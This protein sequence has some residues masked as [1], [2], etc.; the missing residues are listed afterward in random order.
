MADWENL[1]LTF[2]QNK[3]RTTRERVLFASLKALSALFFAGWWIKRASYKSGLLPRKRLA[4]PVISVGNL[5]TGG[6]GK[7]P[8]VIELAK[9]FAGEGRRVAILSR[10]YGRKYKESSLVWVSDGKKILASAEEGGDEPVLIARSVPEAA[11]VVCKDRHRAG[12][13]AMERFKPDL[14]ILDDGYQRRFEVRRDLDIV[15]IDG[16]NPFSTGWVLPAGLLREPL[17]ALSDAGVFVINKVNMSRSPEDIRTVLQHHNPRAYLV[18]AVYRP[19]RLRD[20]HTGKEM[21]PSALDR[22]SVGVFSGVANSLSVVRTL[23]EHKVLVRH[24][25]DLKDHYAYTKESLRAILADARLRGLQYLVTTEKDEVKLPRDMELDIPIL[26]LEIEWH[27]A[28]GKHHWD[29]VL[30]SVS[31]ACSDGKEKR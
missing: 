9:H 11:V 19:G 27:V 3:P 18:E 22:V 17:S 21:K 5:T 2:L 16:G 15:T 25:Y 14:F 8:V 29:T 28:A 13:E 4:C 7:T 30:K 1:Y 20:F 12:L 10:G 6:T 23:S 24:S 31:L 26:V